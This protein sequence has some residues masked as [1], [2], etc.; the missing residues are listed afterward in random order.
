MRVRILRYILALL[1]VGILLV[2]LWSA[3]CQRRET[4]VSLPKQSQVVK[5]TALIYDPERTAG[6]KAA[7]EFTI[8][9][10]YYSLIL[11]A[12]TPAKFK[13]NRFLGRALGKIT[14]QAKDAAQNTE[15]IFFPEGQNPLTFTVN[16]KHC[17]R[18]GKYKPVV[19][20]GGLPMYLDEAMRFTVLLLGI[21]Q[22]TLTGV[23]P[24]SFR[25]TVEEL[26]RSWGELP[27][28]T[29]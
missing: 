27:P 6:V 11:K 26:R 10:E 8:P 22:K 28:W 14:I 23:E 2:G 29:Q 1:S 21:R 9:S 5:M 3:S 13:E 20:G 15:V 24:P 18:G 16:G 25:V 12:I 17:L 7:P 19:I 4:T